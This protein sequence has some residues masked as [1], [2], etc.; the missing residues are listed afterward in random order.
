MGSW[1]KRRRAAT[2]ET[3]SPSEPMEDYA[4]V[5]RAVLGVVY[6]CGVR[7]SQLH[8]TPEAIEI[9][10]ARIAEVRAWAQTVPDP[11]VRRAYREWLDYYE[12]EARE[13]Q[14]DPNTETQRMDSYNRK[15]AR[16]R[17]EVADYEDRSSVPRPP[18]FVP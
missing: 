17:Q 11:Q 6:G 5:W 4:V 13:A 12:G 9:A 1:F 16:E 2:A 18:P 7:I 10:L 3:A 8:P 15:L 14:R